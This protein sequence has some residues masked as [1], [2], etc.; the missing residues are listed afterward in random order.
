MP[1]IELYCLNLGMT[2]YGYRHTSSGAFILKGISYIEIHPNI[3]YKIRM[4]LP[5]TD[6]VYDIHGRK[7]EVIGIA[8]ASDDKF[9]TRVVKS[10][11]IF[12]QSQLFTDPSKATEKNNEQIRLQAEKLLREREKL[13]EIEDELPLIEKVKEEKSNVQFSKEQASVTSKLDNLKRA[14]EKLKSMSDKIKN[15]NKMLKKNKKSPW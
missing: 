8:Q 4:K 1:L 2:F 6:K 13:Q 3:G 11:E 12:D 10:G 9:K 15:V 14:K 5:V 7:Y